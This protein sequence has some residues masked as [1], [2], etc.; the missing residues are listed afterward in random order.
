MQDNVTRQEGTNNHQSQFVRQTKPSYL[1]KMAINAESCGNW[2][3][4]FV[5]YQEASSCLRGHN[6][7]PFNI[8]NLSSRCSSRANQIYQKYF[9]PSIIEEKFLDLIPNTELEE[10]ILPGPIMITDILT[11]LDA[12]EKKNVELEK[13][14][15]ELEKKNSELE[16]VNGNLNEKL[17]T[18]LSLRTLKKY[19]GKDIWQRVGE[20]ESTAWA[21]WQNTKENEKKD[22]N[23]RFQGIEE[24]INSNKD[25]ITEI[26]FL[27]SNSGNQLVQVIED[28]EEL[29]NQQVPEAICE[30][31]DKIDELNEMNELNTRIDEAHNKCGMI[32]KILNA[33]NL[34]NEITNKNIPN[35]EEENEENEDS[36]SEISDESSIA[37]DSLT[38]NEDVASFVNSVKMVNELNHLLSQNDDNKLNEDSDL[39]KAI[40]MSIESFEQTVEKEKEKIEE[41]KKQ[42]DNL[43]SCL[44]HY[45]TQCKTKGRGEK[46]FMIKGNYFCTSIC[47]K[48]YQKE[49][50]PSKGNFTSVMNPAIYN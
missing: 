9:I 19:N 3:D 37:S 16:N 2:E 24:K 6:Q 10:E 34:P 40:Q 46:G 21:A 45:C 1:I 23:L 17:N 30:I 49:K 41:L 13:K 11:R 29:K 18:L 48:Q 28:I 44:L 42:H 32:W 14:N 27:A 50:S 20:L 15:V 39:N 8:P 22:I 47:S 35:N 12:L 26:G 5:Y 36:D 4:A 38:L 7:S 43:Q 33:A 31:A 25:L